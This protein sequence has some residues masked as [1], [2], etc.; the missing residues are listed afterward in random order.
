[1]VLLLLAPRSKILVLSL[2]RCAEALG[3]GEDQ[4]EH[5]MGIGRTAFEWIPLH[6]KSFNIVWEVS[7]P[8]FEWFSA[9]VEYRT[10]HG[11]NFF[12]K[13]RWLYS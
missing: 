1:M 13:Q 12:C 5:E 8:A 7:R 3:V 2:F 4:Q 9:R 10:Y 11:F 6:S